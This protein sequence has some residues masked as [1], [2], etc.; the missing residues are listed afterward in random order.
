MDLEISIDQ[1]D[2]NVAELSNR[3][4]ELE[5]ELAKLQKQNADMLVVM[6][7]FREALFLVANGQVE[8]VGV[9]NGTLKLKIIK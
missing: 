3:V 1:T 6:Q 7:S 8:K 2:N 5:D 9:H 4:E